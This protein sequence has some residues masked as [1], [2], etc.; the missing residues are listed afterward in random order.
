MSRHNQVLLPG[1][2]L[3]LIPNEM[4]D[5]SRSFWWRNRSKHSEI[6]SAINPEIV[7]SW[8]IA[9]LEQ[10]LDVNTEMRRSGF[11]MPDL[12]VRSVHP[13]R[14]SQLT[15]IQMQAASIYSLLFQ[16][17]IMFVQLAGQK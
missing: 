6:S 14:G 9:S 2:G 4:Y 11:E 17:F 3:E 1:S 12:L 7:I 10:K 15:K 13:V 16:I 8:I 5:W